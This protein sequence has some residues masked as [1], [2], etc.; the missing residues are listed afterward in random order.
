MVGS[1]RK[2]SRREVEGHETVGLGPVDAVEGVEEVEKTS[3]TVSI[4]DIAVTKNRILVV[5]CVLRRKATEMS[6]WLQLRSRND[7]LCLH[8]KLFITGLETVR[9]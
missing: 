3:A 9:W 2:E 7:N 5:R 4:S 8:P 6:A 1:L